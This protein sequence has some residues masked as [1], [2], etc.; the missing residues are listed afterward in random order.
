MKEG[1]AIR[2]KISE[3]RTLSTGSGTAEDIRRDTGV[4][5][6]AS[7]GT[8]RKK[9]DAEQHRTCA[10]NVDQVRLEGTAAE[11]E[12]FRL[13]MIPPFSSTSIAC[14]ESVFSYPSWFSDS[15]GKLIVFKLFLKRIL[16]ELW[17]MLVRS[18]V[19]SSILLTTNLAI[20]L[21]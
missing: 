13:L 20:S 2:R 5:A 19:E 12:F 7:G 1:R 17:N 6:I 18:Q 9:N 4:T 3:R 8:T 21:R 16:S 15:G 10:R 11:K 14:F